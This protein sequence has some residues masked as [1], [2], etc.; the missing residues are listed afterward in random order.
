MPPIRC[1]GRNYPEGPITHRVG[2]DKRSPYYLQVKFETAGIEQYEPYAGQ[3]VLL[4]AS[5]LVDTGL[6]PRVN[7]NTEEVPGPFHVNGYVSWGTELDDRFY[8]N[9]DFQARFDPVWHCHYQSDPEKAIRWHERFFPEAGEEL[10][11][12]AFSGPQRTVD[13]ATVR[14]RIGTYDRIPANSC[15]P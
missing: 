2:A 5:P 13:D 8:L 1:L 9:L 15:L 3:W 10:F 11:F 7:W 14:L 4:L 6:N 12:V